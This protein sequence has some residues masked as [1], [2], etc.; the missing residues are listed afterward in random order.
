MRQ[1]CP[2]MQ[3]RARSITLS[4]V[5]RRCT[6]RVDRVPQRVELLKRDVPLAGEDVGGELAPVRGGEKICVGG[7]DA[8]V[9]EVVSGTG[10]VAVC[11]LE[12]AKGV[13]GGDLG[14]R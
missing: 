12:L 3:L 8:E 2:R 13:E 1:P 6:T 10:V 14:G 9:V 5:R 11:V 4:R 7:E